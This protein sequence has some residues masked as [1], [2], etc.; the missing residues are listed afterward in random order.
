MLNPFAQAR[1][2]ISCARLA[3]LP[4]DGQ[5]EVAFA[6]RSNAGKSSALNSICG[7]RQLARVSKTPGR[8]QLINLFELADGRRLADLPGYGFAQV[9]E[10][11][12][13]SW[14]QLI[15]GYMEKRENLRAL[16]LIMDIRHPLT[17][18]DTQML[19][20]ADGAG[21]ACHILLTKADKLGFGAAKQQLM[22]TQK[23]LRERQSAATVQLF[24]S[25]KSTG[26]E[27]ARERIDE[28]L[29]SPAEPTEEEAG[30]TPAL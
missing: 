11:V 14:G 23:A 8:T 17:D 5:P 30:E 4:N 13:R 15:G 29:G 27:E 20:W 12:R 16:V 6:G 10:A 19:D 25:L 21:L 3:Q 26:L 7:R 1:F 9:P 24:S 28:I 18:Y 2:T 22:N